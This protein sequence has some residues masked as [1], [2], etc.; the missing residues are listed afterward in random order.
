MS[1]RTPSTAPPGEAGGPPSGPRY[2]WQ[3]FVG[4]LLAIL[5]GGAILALLL[6]VNPLTFQKMAP[7]PEATS[8]TSAPAVIAAATPAPTATPLTVPTTAPGVAP[9]AV[10]TPMPTPATGVAPQ[11]VQTPASISTARMTPAATVTGGTTPAEPTAAS[12]ESTGVPNGQPQPTPVQAAV[13]P[14]LAAAIIKGYND[15]WSVRVRAMGDPG[16]TSVD[17]ESVMAG[18][19]LAIARKTLA[20]YQNDGQA[21]QTT[22]K[23]QIWITRA[24]PDQ[25]DIVDQYIAS[26]LKVDPATKQPVE[27]QPEIEQLTGKFSLQSFNGDWKVVTESYQ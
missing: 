20:E 8:T 11:A 26:T 18:D 24:S 19:E 5:V 10:P 16:D 15:Y 9:T 25:A 22:V 6:G 1:I 2:P 7:A 3:V 14:E 23:H 21:F 12:S 4:M 13:P 27:S 17:L